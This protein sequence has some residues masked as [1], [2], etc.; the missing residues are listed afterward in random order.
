MKHRKDGNNEHSHKEN[1]PE[2][3]AVARRAYQLYLE[4]GGDPGHDFE[5]W[6][7][8][9]RELKEVRKVAMSH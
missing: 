4:R 9:E 3:E 7:Q 5:D 1:N 6:L 8:A 2:P